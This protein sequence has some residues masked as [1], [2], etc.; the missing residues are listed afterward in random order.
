MVTIGDKV[1]P[2]KY[3]KAIF[4]VCQSWLLTGS[5]GYF[6]VG[7]DHCDHIPEKKG[8]FIHA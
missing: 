2:R 8:K 5:G 6:V 1:E 4:C 3:C 7:T